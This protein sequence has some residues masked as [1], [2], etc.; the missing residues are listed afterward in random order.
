MKENIAYRLGRS[1]GYGVAVALLGLTLGGCSA[2]KPISEAHE[3]VVKLPAAHIEFHK[4]MLSD[5]KKLYPKT[6]E[7]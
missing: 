1:G 5:Q 7:K 2:S 3:T 4:K 6:A